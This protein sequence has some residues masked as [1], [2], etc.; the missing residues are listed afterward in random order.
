M[1]R[2]HHGRDG[3]VVRSAAPVMGLR[4]D[5]E[6]LAE[7]QYPTRNAT[8]WM[9]LRGAA[10]RIRRILQSEQTA[11]LSDVD[12]LEIGVGSKL[13]E[14]VLDVVVDRRDLDAEDVGDV[15]GAGAAG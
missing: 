11:L 14:D 12:R 10:K 2:L 9:G 5:A 6:A 8:L 3:G 7:G 15:L 13:V 1:M 4:D